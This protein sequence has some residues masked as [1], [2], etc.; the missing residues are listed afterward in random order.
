MFISLLHYVRHYFLKLENTASFCLFLFFS[1]DKYYSRNLTKNDTSVDGVL[2][3]RTWGGRMVGAG[4]ST[5]LWRHLY[6]RH[7]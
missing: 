3:T 6:V 2:G 1:N 5:E 4:E 7:S